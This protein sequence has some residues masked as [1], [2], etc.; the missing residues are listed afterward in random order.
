[1]SLHARL[2][3]TDIGAIRQHSPDGGWLIIEAWVDFV[4]RQLRVR[5]G[6]DKI[7]H[8]PLDMFRPAGDGAEP[9]FA[10]VWISPDGQYVGFGRY[11]ASTDSIL[12]AAGYQGP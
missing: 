4:G 6:C 2:L 10:D 5:T 7:L 9:D 3:S 1:M 12:E 8:V 11:E